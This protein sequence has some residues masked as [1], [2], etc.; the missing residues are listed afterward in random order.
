MKIVLEKIAVELTPE[1][2][3]LLLTMAMAWWQGKKRR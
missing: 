3:C 1:M 2:F